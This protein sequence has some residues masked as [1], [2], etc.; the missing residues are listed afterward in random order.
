MRKQRLLQTLCVLTKGRG[1]NLWGYSLCEDCI[2]A[3]R[4]RDKKKMGNPG[5]AGMQINNYFSILG[6]WTQ[7]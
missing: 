5:N 4:F 3:H 1:I 6:P 2:D 7:N